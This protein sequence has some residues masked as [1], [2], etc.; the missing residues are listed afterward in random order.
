M[1]SCLARS[2][3]HGYEIKLELRYRHVRWWAKCEHGHLYSALA[4][5]ERGK[6]IRAVKEVKDDVDGRGK[7]VFAVTT[8]GRRRLAQALESI[9]LS[10][11]FTYFDIDLFLAGAFTMPQ[12]RVV[13]I[14]EHRVEVLRA[15]LGEADSVRT[16]AGEYVPLAGR[17]IIHHR[18]EYLQRE[19]EFAERA[20]AAVRAEPTWGPYLGAQSIEKFLDETHFPLEPERPRRRARAK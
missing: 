1:L 5:L 18:I 13:E 9:G 11:D 8:S 17:L 2:P 14:L 20:A 4:R 10:E 6:F 19:V 7:R 3:M 16:A 15:Q 12:A